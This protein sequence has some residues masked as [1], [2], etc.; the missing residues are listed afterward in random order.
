[1]NRKKIF[2]TILLVLVVLLLLKTCNDYGDRK[3]LLAQISTYEIGNKA[4]KVKMQKDSSTIASQEQ[5]ILTHKEAIRLGLLKLDG[6]I[7][8]AQSQVTQTQVVKIQKVEVAY[9][10]NNYADTT[11]WRSWA[12][13]GIINDTIC[14][15]LLA[16]AVI[17]PKTFSTQNKWYS[18]NGEVKKNG[19]LFDS[20][21]VV[22]ESKVTIGWKRGG[23][24]GLKKI[25]VV[26]IKN[27]NPYISVPKMDN[28]VVDPD[29][30]VFQK[31]GFWLGFGA[32]I[33]YFLIK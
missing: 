10:P 6:E 30:S 27:T 17:L 13:K 18:I 22:N 5:T 23:F 3:K 33:T 14:D 32:L 19:V 9:V 1:M 8:K 16:N 28:V 15:S 31:K 24:L 25:P 21:K 26:E 4:F 7:K 11:G 2:N 20:I 12:E 29:K